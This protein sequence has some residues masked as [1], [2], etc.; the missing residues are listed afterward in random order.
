MRIGLYIYKLGFG[1]AERVV[2]RTSQIL[3]RNGHQVFVIL[4]ERIEEAYAFAGDCINL[5]VPHKFHGV[6][7]LLL[8]FRRI[9]AL[10]KA[11]KEKQ[12]DVV[13]SFLLQPNIINVLSKNK[14]CKSF[15]SIRNRF[16]SEKYKSFFQKFFFF[17]A[18][19]LYKKADGVISVSNLVNYEAI[20]YLNVPKEKSFTLYNPYD[21]KEIQIEADKN[22]DFELN[23]ILS[24][25][26]YK[27]V[28]TGRFTHQ[29]GFWHLIKAF[30]IV[31]K[32]LPNTK[33]IINGDGE[34]RA[35][36]EKLISDFGLND[37]IILT[38]F[39]KDVFAIEKQ[40]NCYVL[41]SLFE[42]FPNSLAEALCIGLPIIATDC[43]SGPREILLPNKELN[44]SINSINQ[45]DYGFLLQELEEYE[46]WDANYI[47]AGEMLLADVMKRIINIKF[48]KETIKTRAT[49]F[50]EEVFYEKLL[51][52]LKT[53]K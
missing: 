31:N 48:N 5:N 37:K 36:I 20:Q 30:S 14:K 12:L 25:N 50:S 28:S 35:K 21:I 38:G 18:K 23:E 24:D 45:T 33:L 16:L 42:G 26:T 47:S 7:S 49:V 8:F 2:S 9:K 51:S 4:D 44:E 19:C 10:K 39:R 3:Q 46:D 53:L 13:I 29:K 32:D 43:K 52:I 15:V 11:K 1:G 17:L 27:F 6:K 40:C 22:L 41:S 34:Q